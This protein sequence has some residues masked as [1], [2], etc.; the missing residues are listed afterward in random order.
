M[1]NYGDKVVLEAAKSLRQEN[2]DEHVAQVE[3]VLISIADIEFQLKKAKEKL[4]HL[5]GMTLD[6]FIEFRQ[7]TKYFRKRK[8]LRR[9]LRNPEKEGE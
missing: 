2:K 5:R 1:S 7:E 6:E 3:D 4:D 9:S 8:Y